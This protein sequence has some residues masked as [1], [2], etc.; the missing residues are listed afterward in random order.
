VPDDTKLPGELHEH[1]VAAGRYACTTHV[2]PY[3]TL[4]DTW[5]NF[6]GH[7]MPS[8]GH[9]HGPGPSLEIYRNDPRTTPKAALITEICV[10]VA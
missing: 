9:T 10:P 3:E 7:W 8:S 6:M 2:G 4:G 1:R 5:M